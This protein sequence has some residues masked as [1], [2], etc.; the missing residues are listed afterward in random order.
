MGWPVFAASELLRAVLYDAV[1]ELAGASICS[2]RHRRRWPVFQVLELLRTAETFNSLWAAVNF[3][4]AGALQ[5]LEPLSFHRDFYIHTD[6]RIFLH[7]ARDLSYIT[8]I[9]SIDLLRE[10]LNTN[11]TTSHGMQYIF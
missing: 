7:S 2:S 5:V 3:R 4:C 10:V 9:H 8:R 11:V 1:T 6:S